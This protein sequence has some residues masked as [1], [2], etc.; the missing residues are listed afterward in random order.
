[1]SDNTLRCIGLT[2][3]K[4]EKL[5]VRGCVRVTGIGIEAILTGCPHL[6]YL[7]VS[8]C[9]HLQPWLDSPRG[10]HYMQSGRDIRTVADGKWRVFE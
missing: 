3:K 10:Q 2:L 8:Q 9:R 5:S 1:M 6:Q 7:D 4:L